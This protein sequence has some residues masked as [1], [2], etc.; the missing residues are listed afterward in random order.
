MN[1]AQKFAAVV[2]A[3]LALLLI[4]AVAFVVFALVGIEFYLLVK[5]LGP[6]QGMTAL[7]NTG[8]NALINMGAIGVGFWLARQRQ[9]QDNAAPSAP[10]V[11]ATLNASTS[12]SPPPPAPAKAP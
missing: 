9:Q 10:T 4:G 2:Q 11:T 8:F 3:L 6:D 12:P 5:K 1:D 7:L